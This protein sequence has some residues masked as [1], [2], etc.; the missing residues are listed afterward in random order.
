MPVQGKPK[1]FVDFKK[2]F[3]KGILINKSDF[4]LKFFNIKGFVE[5]YPI[6]VIN[7]KDCKHN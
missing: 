7:N 1:L 3:K 6:G 4:N 5:N 2:L